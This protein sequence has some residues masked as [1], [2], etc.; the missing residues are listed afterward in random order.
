MAVTDN[1][2]VDSS[3]KRL[4]L[5]TFC[6]VAIAVPT[7]Y[8]PLAYFALAAWVIGGML[9]GQMSDPPGWLVVAIEPA[10]NVTFCMWPIYIA[11]VAISRRLT[12][13]EKTWWLFIVLLM[14]MVGMPI[15]YVFM[16]R[17]YLGLEGR[18]NKQDELSLDRFLLR[19]SLSRK[20]F[21]PDQLSVLRS[22]CRS[23]RQGRWAALVMVPLA[24]FMLY[25]ALVFLP[26]NS[27]R[28]FSDL[29][30]TRTIFVNTAAQ[31]EDEVSPDLEMR[32]QYTQMVMMFGALAGTLGFMSM[33]LLVTTIVQVR[34]TWE[35]KA[36]IEFVKATGSQHTD[37]V[38]DGSSPNCLR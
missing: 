14:N 37:N 12:W 20:R 24:A 4:P 34:G 23:C 35:R 29:T 26:S 28:I 5:P 2:A 15:F 11:W 32:R 19:H 27:L 13:K 17:R 10:L 8:M 16:I 9:S 18:P 1:T 25:A 22:F 7:F 33:L 21:S 30:P 36:L 31:T 3:S 6:F 38:C